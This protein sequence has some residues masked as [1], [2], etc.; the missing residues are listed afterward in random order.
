MAA[1]A[2]TMQAGREP[3]APDRGG[4][5]ATR[6]VMVLSCGTRV[7]WLTLPAAKELPHRS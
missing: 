1:G 2:A 7:E 5:N 4:W 6:D 3:V